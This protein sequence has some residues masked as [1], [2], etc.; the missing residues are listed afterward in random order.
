MESSGGLSV[1]SPGSGR[2]EGL[3]YAQSG[4]DHINYEFD[5]PRGKVSDIMRIMGLLEKKFDKL[6][7][8]ISANEGHI[9]YQDLSNL[10]EALKQIGINPEEGEQ[11]D[12]GERKSRN[13]P[14]PR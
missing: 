12:S 8:K 5:V 13:K 14:C 2:Q 3:S 9:S 7:I 11:K 10:K 6:H 4:I 1:T